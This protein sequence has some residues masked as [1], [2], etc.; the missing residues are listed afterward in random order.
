MVLNN[1]PREGK[2]K[3]RLG[4]DIGYKASAQFAKYMLED[5]VTVAS[6][7]CS[8]TVACPKNDIDDFSR[9]YPGWDFYQRTQYS[10]VLGLP[11]SFRYIYNKNGPKKVIAVTGD[12]IINER[13]LDSWF[14]HLDRFNILAGPTFDLRFY[15]GGLDEKYGSQFASYLD[16]YPSFANFLNSCISIMAKVPKVKIVKRKIDIDTLDDLKSISFPDSYRKTKGFLCQQG[17][18]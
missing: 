9:A 13:E 6:K 17:Y 14:N 12:I 11:D 18:I 8:I 4:K 3:T 1:F 15:L 16:K 7:V 10:L 2:S 5:I